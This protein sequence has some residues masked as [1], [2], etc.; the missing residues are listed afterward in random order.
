MIFFSFK[1][2][3]NV[4]SKSNS[5]KKIEKKIFFVGALKV[6]DEKSR[7]LSRIRS[8]EIRP[9]WILFPK[10]SSQKCGFGIR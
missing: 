1:D 8:S 4:L 7:I 9:H 3:V 5:K 10:K 2:D 6:T